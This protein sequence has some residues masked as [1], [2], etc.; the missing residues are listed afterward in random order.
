MHRLLWIGVVIGLLI[1]PLSVAAQ[2]L[3]VAPI[4]LE[5]PAPGA[6]A[7]L[8]LRNDSREPMSVQ[9]RTYRWTQQNGAE[10]LTRSSDVV[11]SPPMT[12]LAPGAVQTVR[13]VRTSKSPVNR[14]EAYRVI[15]DQIPDLSRQRAGTVAFT[16]QMRIP[17]F[18][19]GGGA[20]IPDVAW[21]LRNSGNALM[22]VAQNRGDTRLR[23]ADLRLAG[24]SGSVRRDGLVGYVLGGSTMQWPLAPAG[25][26]GAGP[27]NLT[28]ATNLGTLNARVGRQ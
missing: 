6:T 27:A 1:A 7:T 16:T 5:V 15:V 4:T 14:E 23:V 17:V 26:L 11:V 12:R 25:R 2:G 10:R 20:R 18:F 21:S 9:L 28:A 8:T 3:R 24:G 22:L 13:I 19:V